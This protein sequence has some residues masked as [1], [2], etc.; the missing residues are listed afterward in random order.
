MSELLA[1][2]ATAS[3]HGIAGVL[4]LKR[5]ITS[6]QAAAFMPLIH[7]IY[8]IYIRRI[9]FTMCRP[10]IYRCNGP[11]TLSDENPL[12]FD[13]NSDCSRAGYHMGHGS[14]PRHIDEFFV[15]S[16]GPGNGADLGGLKGADALCQKM[17][18]AGGAASG[19]WRVYLSVSANDGKAAVNARDRMAKVPGT[20]PKELK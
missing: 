10:S 13:H 17:A 6:W 18:A 11:R 3:A 20:M 2:E 19:N 15:T 1:V 8:H 5:G 4:L 7:Y 16:A 14:G 12:P 9:P